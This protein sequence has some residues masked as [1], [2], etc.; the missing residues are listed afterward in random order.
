MKINGEIPG[1]H[2]TQCWPN[3]KHSTNVDYLLSLYYP[4]QGN[5]ENFIFLGLSVPHSKQRKNDL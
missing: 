2:L 1:T 5:T 4:Q 3:S